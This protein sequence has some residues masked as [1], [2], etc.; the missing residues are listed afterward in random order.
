MEQQ[1]CIFIHFAAKVLGGEIY[2]V[3]YF[4]ALDISGSSALVGELELYLGE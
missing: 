1:K 2:K 4:G 3:G